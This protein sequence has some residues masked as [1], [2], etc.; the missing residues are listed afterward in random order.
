MESD[1]ASSRCKDRVGRDNLI[2]KALASAGI[3]IVQFTTR[4]ACSVQAVKIRLN[5]VMFLNLAVSPKILLDTDALQETCLFL[6]SV[7]GD[8]FE[9][10]CQLKDGHKALRLSFNEV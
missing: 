8:V 4:K 2:D 7:N 1:D 3:P 6:Q 5:E 10:L 9:E